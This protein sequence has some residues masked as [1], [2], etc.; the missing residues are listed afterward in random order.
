MTLSDIDSM[1]ALYLQAERDVLAGKQ[2]T[3]QGRTVTSE[4]LSEIRKGRMEWEER[5]MNAVNPRRLP[6]SLARFS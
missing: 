6:Y 2:V 4:N 1:I 5:R 3:F